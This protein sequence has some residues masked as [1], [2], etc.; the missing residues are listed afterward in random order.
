MSVILNNENIRF[1]AC[2][3]FERL[4]KNIYSRNYIETTRKL[5]FSKHLMKNINTSLDIEFTYTFS[6]E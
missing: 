1:N 3:S 6:K 4:L 2:F 5:S